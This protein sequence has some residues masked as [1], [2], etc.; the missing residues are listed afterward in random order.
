MDIDL[1][2]DVITVSFLREFEFSLE[3]LHEVMGKL[4]NLENIKREMIKYG[5]FGV[6]VDEHNKHLLT[7]SDN[8]VSVKTVINSMENSP[9]QSLG[10]YGDLSL[11]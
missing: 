1:L 2:E 5:K 8:M 6:S 7:I 4:K 11:N 3:E 10:L 9:F